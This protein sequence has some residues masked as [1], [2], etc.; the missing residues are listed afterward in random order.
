M[1]GSGIGL[2]LGSYRGGSTYAPLYETF[3]IVPLI[4]AMAVACLPIS[5]Y[6][7]RRSQRPKPVANQWQA[8]AAM[9][10]LG[11]RGWRARIN[12]YGSGAPAPVDAPP[13]RVPLVELE[14]TQFDEG[15]EHLLAARRL[16]APTIGEALQR[17]VDE[18]RTDIVLEQIERAADREGEL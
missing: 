8:L 10:E 13:S 12:L 17:M 3:V 1:S 18:R 16:W 6:I 7:R 11:A 9:S 2:V 4:L 15:C 5:R 14:W